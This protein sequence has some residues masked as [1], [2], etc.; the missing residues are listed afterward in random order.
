MLWLLQTRPG[1]LET[2]GT[3]TVGCPS[4]EFALLAGV[5]TAAVSFCAFW[6][7]KVSR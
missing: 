6:D 3:E 5:V 1:G 4:M 2:M 7:Q